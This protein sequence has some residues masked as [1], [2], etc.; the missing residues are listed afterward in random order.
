[1]SESS[2]S[3]TEE[4]VLDPHPRSASRLFRMIWQLENWLRLMVYVELRA[5][6]PNWKSV[7]DKKITEQ[8]ARTME[9]DKEQHHM[10]TP[11]E[12]ELSYSSLGQLWD[13]ISSEEIWPYFEPYFPPRDNVKARM[14]E[15]RQIRN[16]IAHFRPRHSLDEQRLELF[17]ADMEPGVRRF[18]SRYMFG[19]RGMDSDPVWEKLKAVWDERTYATELSG[20][21]GCLYAPGY[22]RQ[23]PPLHITLEICPHKVREES[24]AGI[25]YSVEVAPPLARFLDI[26]QLLLRTSEIHQQL[27]HIIDFGNAGMCFTLPGA[28]GP[29]ELC[30]HILA[31]AHAGVNSATGVDKKPSRRDWP[32]YYIRSSHWL[33]NLYVTPDQIRE[34]ILDRS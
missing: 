23:D 12:D 29:D 7:V 11:H 17:L 26:D 16:R 25:V 28:V 20:P 14:E 5:W 22:K 27:I 2:D 9:R 15:V 10:T 8:A 13:I 34:Q 24:T 30:E 6:L 18:C 32:E 4:Y 33:A 31:I 1:M 3:T 19:R 21:L